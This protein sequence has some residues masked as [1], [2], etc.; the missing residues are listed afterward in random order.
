MYLTS[1]LRLQEYHFVLMSD[2]LIYESERTKFFQFPP[3]RSKQKEYKYEGETSL[4]TSIL[5]D[6]AADDLQLAVVS[7]TDANDVIYF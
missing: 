1:T 7:N 2:R 4:Q 6:F 5:I 3:S